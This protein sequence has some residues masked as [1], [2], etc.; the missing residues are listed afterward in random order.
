[1]LGL[2]INGFIG[3]LAVKKHQG[4][5]IAFCITVFKGHA[6]CNIHI[7]FDNKI[8]TDA[9][10]ENM[11]RIDS[12]PNAEDFLAHQLNPAVIGFLHHFSV[13]FHQPA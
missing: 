8:S 3:R 13:L 11:E 1:M 6:Q 10:D 5:V 9:E 2:Q 4:E 7:G 12:S